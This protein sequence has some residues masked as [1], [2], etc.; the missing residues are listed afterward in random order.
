M[1]GTGTLTFSGRAKL[2]VGLAPWDD[3]ELE[4]R[5][6]RLRVAFEN[7]TVNV[8]AL[9]GRLD[10][11]ATDRKQ[12]DVDHEQRLDEVHTELTDLI[13]TAAAGGLRLQ[14]LGVVLVGVGI[15]LA[16]WG[17]ILGPT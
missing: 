15:V 9:D 14:T 6:G 2:T 3:V 1:S 11:E 16:T 4:E 13:R 12:H 7:L 8:D 5:V 17:S 10:E